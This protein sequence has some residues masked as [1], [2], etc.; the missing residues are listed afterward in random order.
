MEAQHFNDLLFYKLRTGSVYPYSET[1]KACIDAVGFD[2][3][4]KVACSKG[5]YVW[6][7]GNIAHYIIVS[8]FDP[9]TCFMSYNAFI[10][11]GD[12]RVENINLAQAR[13]AL[14]ALYYLF[15][16]F[17]VSVDDLDYYNRTVKQ[18]FMFT[19]S[20]GVNDEIRSL[21]PAFKL[22]I[23]HG[24]RSVDIYNNYILKW[25]EYNRKKKK[26]AAVKIANWWLNIILS[27]YNDIGRRYLGG[28]ANG[29]NKFV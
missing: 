6:W 16:H 27:P 28:I 24:A 8:V 29:W 18:H 13:D 21:I 23:K 5:A 22:L 14:Y 11:V 15:V 1:I 19:I 2:V 4:K 9:K 10:E 7:F 12:M 25:A 3:F 20:D 17:D 26:E